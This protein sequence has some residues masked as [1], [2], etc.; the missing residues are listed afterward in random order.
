MII[1]N[2]DAKPQSDDLRVCNDYSARIIKNAIA[3]PLIKINSL[4]GLIEDGLCNLSTSKAKKTILYVN[5]YYFSN[6]Q[7]LLPLHIKNHISWIIKNNTKYKF[8]LKDLKKIKTKKNM[9]IFYHRKNINFRFLLTDINFS[10]FLDKDISCGNFCMRDIKPNYLIIKSNKY[11]NK[12]KKTIMFKFIYNNYED[13]KMFEEGESDFT[14]PTTFP[15]ELINNSRN[16]LHIHE[17]NVLLSI[18]FMNRKLLNSEHLNLRKMIFYS[19]NRK[20]IANQFNPMLIPIFNFKDKEKTEIGKS[21]ITKI[22]SNIKLVMGYDNFYPNKEI[23][24]IIKEMLEKNNIKLELKET[25]FYNRD[26]AVDLQLNLTYRDYNHKSF[27]YLSK[28]FELLT[29]LS[30]PFDYKKIQKLKYKYLKK[31]DDQSFD[32]LT[33][34]I[35]NLYIEI[36]LF[37]E[38]AIFLSKYNNFNFNSFNFQDL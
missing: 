22:D 28:Y 20:L 17:N 14:N 4:N 23:S 10:P 8:M 26:E 38:N 21:A 2:L 33:K 11:N 37:I 29:K 1:F 24:L 5:E 13:V 36:P 31:G 7:K 25:N 30:S 19:I 35:D 32:Q 27:Y 6:G 3:I 18:S 12:H 9:I 34:T 16:S 15:V